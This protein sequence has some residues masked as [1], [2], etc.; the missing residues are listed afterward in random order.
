MSHAFDP[1][2]TTIPLGGSTLVVASPG[3]S[4][5]EQAAALLLTSILREQG[6]RVDVVLPGKTAPDQPI[7]PEPV[8]DHLPTFRLLTVSLP[9]HQTPLA[10]LSYL[11]QDKELKLTITP[12]QGSWKPE[13]VRAETQAPR[14]KLLI[15]LPGVQTA[16]LVALAPHDPE[17]F[18]ALPSVH[19]TLESQAALGWATHTLCTEPSTSIC[20]TLV[21]WREASAQ[22]PLTKEQAHLALTGMIA[23][24]KGF[25]DERLQSETLARASRLIERGADRQAIM[26]ALWR[27]QSVATLNVWGRAL[28]RIVLHPTSRIATFL[29]SEHD[30][31]QSRASPSILPRLG[32]YLVDQ[33]PEQLGVCALYSWQSKIYL[34]VFWRTKQPPEALFANF[35][36]A[37]EAGEHTYLL[38]APDLVQ[39]QQAFFEHLTHHA[40]TSV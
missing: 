40:P 13:D 39:A 21:A 18:Q 3:A 32:E 26:N 37:P 15:A 27:T 17:W 2:G 25:R 11:V 33:L 38:D 20:E 34:R 30:F 12:K 24:T 28:M 10:E 1:L 6:A 8:F 19:L 14:Y 29:L 5:D 36:P 7:P 35:V 23:A 22:N 31:L 4:L 16:D 9:V